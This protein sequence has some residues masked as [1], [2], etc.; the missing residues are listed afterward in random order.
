MVKIVFCADPLKPRYPDEVYQAEVDAV[1]TLGFNYV[2]I[3][4][5]ALVNENNPAKAVQ[6]IPEQSPNQLG[7]YR[8]W[9]LTPNQYDELYNVLSN[10]GILLINDPTAYTHCHYLP[11]S[12]SVI[13]GYTPKSI[14]LKIGDNVSIDEIMSL[15]QPFGSKPIVL[16]DFVKSQKH[17]WKEA[18]FIPSASNREAVERVVHRFIEL[19]AEDLNEGLV[20]REFIEFEPL[21]KHSKSGMPLTREFRL[22]ILDGE[23]FYVAEY[24][25]EGDY[26][27]IWPGLEEFRIIAHNVRSRFFT[28]DVAKQKDGEWKWMIIE[29]GDAQVA[30]LPENID[31]QG[32][33]E[34]LHKYLPKNLGN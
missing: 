9:M 15:L 29:L 24:W 17:Y 33:Y 30:G 28:M 21:T 13:E 26:N 19:Q 2:I 23:I 7:I 27:D 3:N 5:E 8:G 14:W 32:F 18:C 25:E 11:E 10:K 31:A 16:K 34:A 20:F 4:Y 1:N 6:Q 12:Y 22:F